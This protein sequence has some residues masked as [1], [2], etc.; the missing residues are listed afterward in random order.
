VVQLDDGRYGLGRLALHLGLAALEQLDA[1]TIAERRLREFCTSSGLTAMLSL[2]SEN[3]PVVLR[4]IQG[5]R[6]VYTTISVGSLLPLTTSATGIVFLTWLGHASRKSALSK[7]PHRERAQLAERMTMVRAEGWA[8][9]SGDLI[10]G[11]NAVSVPMFDGSGDIFAAFT[12]VT[13]GQSI[14][15]DK[16]SALRAT[17]LAASADV[18]YRA[19]PAG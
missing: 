4:W 19:R 10:P 18:G 8:A 13:A 3:G 5:E 1:T 7:I 2:W 16:I 9:V 15:V 17:A 11:L 12:A 6:P 14:A